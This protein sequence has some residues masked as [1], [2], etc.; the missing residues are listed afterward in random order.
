MELVMK[1][2]FYVS[3]ISYKNLMSFEIRK[4]FKEKY[5]AQIQQLQGLHKSYSH[6]TM[7]ACI[8]FICFLHFFGTDS[9]FCSFSQ[10][11]NFYP[12]FF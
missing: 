8:V 10:K 7:R 11:I 12:P 3:I 1:D 5:N 6:N 4:G 9:V 2:A